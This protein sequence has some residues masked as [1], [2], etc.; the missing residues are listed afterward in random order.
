MGV[1]FR[2]P[3]QNGGRPF[4]AAFHRFGGLVDFF[5]G[6]GHQP[7]QVGQVG[8]GAGKPAGLGK[9][10]GVGIVD[11]VGKLGGFDGLIQVIGVLYRLGITEGNGGLDDAGVVGDGQAQPALGVL[12]DLGGRF[13][14]GFDHHRGAAGGQNQPIGMFAG[15]ALKGVGSFGMD[16]AAWHHPPQQFAQ[17]IVGVGFNLVGHS[18]PPGKVMSAYNIADLGGDGAGYGIAIVIP[19]QAGIPKWLIGNRPVS[20]STVRDS[21][22]RGN[23]GRSG[24]KDGKEGGYS[25]IPACAGMTVGGG[26]KDDCGNIAIFPLTGRKIAGKTGAALA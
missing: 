17:G 12:L 4:D 26:G 8:G 16:G 25:W 20:G 22:L 24:G 11:A 3:I 2:H 5:L 9:A 6:N 23:D 7:N 10:G 18:S 14:F 13:I 15:K 21:R 1:Q 19:A